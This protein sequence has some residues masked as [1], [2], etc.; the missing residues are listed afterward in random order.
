MPQNKSWIITTSADRPIKDIAKDLEDAGFE[1]GNVN[2]VIQSISGVAGDET[3]EKVRKVSGVVDV[4][5]D[6]PIDIGPP[7]SPTT[8]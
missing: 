1:V 7:D 3:L 8:W 5:P 4:S 6:Q 2:D